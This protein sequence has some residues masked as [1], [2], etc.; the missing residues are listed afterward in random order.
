MILD[1][2]DR[3]G[4]T[5][6]VFSRALADSGY[7]IRVRH[8][9]DSP[10]V[11][12]TEDAWRPSS[13]RRRELR[14]RRLLEE[15]G[16]VTFEVHDGSGP[17]EG[18]L[19]EGFAIEHSGWKSDT[20]ISRDAS[21]EGFYRRVASWAADE[22]LLRL[23][24]MR[25]AGKAIAFDLAL[26]DAR[27]HYLLKTGYVTELRRFGPG[28]LLRK[29]MI[30]IAARAGLERYEFT[31]DAEQWKMDWADRVRHIVEI[32]AAAPGAGGTFAR[33]RRLAER[34]RRRLNRWGITWSRR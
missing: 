11:L 4:K 7:S 19:D 16:D 9:L 32:D 23:G 10:Y 20:A 15:I 8:R 30:D 1:L 3:D 27:A 25:L 22:G 26:E 13:K 6:S 31:G 12:L 33:V 17:I 28:M 5:A 29:E 24:F 18:L 34:A 21:V 2:V 14:R